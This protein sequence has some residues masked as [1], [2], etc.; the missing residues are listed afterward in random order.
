MQG[1]LPNPADAPSGSVRRKIL[2]ACF[3][4]LVG[5]AGFPDLPS[6][7][8]RL[9]SE[10]LSGLLRR[11]FIALAPR[12]C[13]SNPLTTEI[14][15]AAAYLHHVRCS[16]AYPRTSDHVGHYCCGIMA[17]KAR[18]AADQPVTR[19]R[20]RSLFW[21]VDFVSDDAADCRT[22]DRSARAAACKNRTSDGAGAGTYGRILIL[23]RHPRTTQH[24]D[25]H[26]RSNCTEHESL[27]CFHGITSFKNNCSPLRRVWDSTAYRFVTRAFA[28]S[29]R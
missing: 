9:L 27:Y 16:V 23:R 21:L 25:E 2:V 17:M 3:R 18:D 10:F 26:C 29:W 15:T 8:R 4:I 13:A 6:G 19:I 12:S 14:T 28:L 24:A 22:A 1:V 20:C 7:F 11:T 5:I